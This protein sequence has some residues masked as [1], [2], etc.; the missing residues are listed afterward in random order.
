MGRLGGSA[1]T[2]AMPARSPRA[3]SGAGRVRA[4]GPGRRQRRRDRAGSLCGA[5]QSARCAATGPGGEAGQQTRRAHATH[6][7]RRP[8]LRRSQGRPAAHRPRCQ[9]RGDPPQRQTV[10]SASVPKN[11]EKPSAASSNGEPAAKAGS[12]TSNAATAGTV[13]AS[14]A[15]KAPGSGPDTASSPTT[16]SRSAPSPHNR[17]SHRPVNASARRCPRAHQS[18][19]NPVTFS[20]RSS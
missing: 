14:T 12:V 10:R 11:I 4:Q 15:P 2:T 20:G 16:W 7:H 9:Q 3:A 5:G 17:E 13:P 6:R 1:C 18:R 8:R 19:S